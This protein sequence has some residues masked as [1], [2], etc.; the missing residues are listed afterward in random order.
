MILRL[1]WSV[2]VTL[3]LACQPSFGQMVPG[4]SGAEAA[5]SLAS[6]GAVCNGAS[7]TADNAAFRAFNAWGKAQGDA[8]VVLNLPPGQTCCM[9]SGA[10]V[11]PNGIRK[12]RVEGNKA[13]LSSCGG[14]TLQQLGGGAIMENNATNALVATVE[15][16]ATSVRLLTAA[17]WSRFAVGRWVMLGAV[18]VQ[19]GSGYPP[20]LAIFEYLKVASIDAATGVIA[21]TAPLRFSYKSTYPNFSAADTYHGGPATLYALHP[22][23]DTEIEFKDLTLNV[24]NNAGNS[25]T[26][27]NGRKVKLNNVMLAGDYRCIAPSAAIEYEIVDSDLSVCE[28]E[29]DKL[30]SNATVTN[31]TGGTF[32]FQ[33]SGGA[34]NMTMRNV[35]LRTMHGTP[36]DLTATN[37]SISGNLAIGAL[38]YGGSRSFHCTNCTVRGAVVPSRTGLEENINA[39]WNITDGVL[40]RIRNISVVTSEAVPAGA[41]V[42][43]FAPGTLPAGVTAGLFVIDNTRNVPRIRPGLTKVAAHTDTSITLT[44]GV[45]APLPSGTS[46]RLISA[47]IPWAFPGANAYY[48][49]ANYLSAVPFQVTDLTQDATYVYVRTNRPGGFPTFD[50]PLSINVHPMP[51]FTCTGC[52]G[53]ADITD[54]ASAPAGDPVFSHSKRTYTGNLGNST[55]RVWGQLRSIKVDVTRPYVTDGALTLKPVGEFGARFVSSR[56]AGLFSALGLT[57][58]V[59]RAGLREITRTGVT[60]DGVPGGCPGDT[61]S[62]L[63]DV[64]ATNL[65]VPHLSAD[66]SGCTTGCGTVSIEVTTDRDPVIPR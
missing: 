57:I 19:G 8:Q 65:F 1:L 6:F 47:E 15:A 56:G 39:R 10:G 63:P 50:A 21:F 52:G 35:S 28:I 24:G 54:L 31:T 34:L 2:L 5:R 66:V 33:S 44:A 25:Q 16:G 43:N 22:T 60:C 18:D 41:T 59:K 53:G 3:C 26:Y 64:R 23:W 13:T 62:P 27:I 14:P 7:T 49:S 51:Q 58:N 9:T 20:N 48:G 38:G 46:V 36:Q 17:Q 32:L 45:V 42:L 30:I 11:W 37:L 61:L 55:Q 4:R 29:W 12:I 40:W